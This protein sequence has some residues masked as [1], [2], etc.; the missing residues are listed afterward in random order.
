VAQ[1]FPANNSKFEAG[2]SLPTDFLLVARPKR[3][4]GPSHKQGM[5]V[6][7]PMK[8]L[9]TVTRCNC[10]SPCGKRRAFVAGRSSSPNVEDYHGQ[11]MCRL[12]SQS[13]VSKSGVKGL[14]MFSVG[15]SEVSR[16][17]KEGTYT[18]YFSVVSSRPSSSFKLCIS[19]LTS[20]LFYFE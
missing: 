7:E 13:A 3:G 5:I 4:S 14:Y 18:F 10:S 6:T 19:L 11:L 2:Y 15:T 8:I 9:L 12:N 17:L 1:T 20:L 16:L